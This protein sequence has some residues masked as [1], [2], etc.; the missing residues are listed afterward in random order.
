VVDYYEILGVSKNASKE[1]IKKAYKNLAKKYHP[2][3]NK[4]NPN[5]TAKFKEINE[6]YSALSDDNKR[7][8]YDRFGST[9][10]GQGY[11]HGFEGFQQGGFS[12]IFESFFGGS[13]GGSGGQ[14]RRRRGQ[15]LKAELDISFNEACFGTE[16]KI[17]VSR[18]ENCESCEGIGGKGEKSCTTC[19]GSGQVRKSYRTPFGVVAQSGVCSQC[20]G[21][22]KIVETSCDDCSGHGRVKNSRTITVKVPKGVSDG[23]TLR[24]TG[25]GE[26]GEP[27]APSGDLYVEI[28]VKPHEVFERKGDDIYLDYPVS[29]SQAALGD[30]V[31]IPTIRDKVSMKIPSGIQSG[32]ILRLRDE[33]VDNVNGRGTGD[34]LVRIHVKTPSKV[35]SKMKKL[36]KDLADENKEKLKIEKGFFEKLREGLS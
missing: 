14:R 23:V 21:F 13:F 24:L 25:E 32:T 16:K 33:G 27:H 5:A 19:Q 12:D 28:Y 36:F 9:E 18:L 26:A 3:L 6:A 11:S 15:D 35:N 4:D 8:N 17:K 2:D 31:K 10:S 30:K 20:G 29:F 7:S 34:Q 22:G 1:E